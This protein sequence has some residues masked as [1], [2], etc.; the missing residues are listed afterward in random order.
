M[1]LN[2]RTESERALKS[3]PSRNLEQLLEDLAA[4]GVRWK[5][6]EPV[7]LP[8]VVFHL[9]SGRD[10]PGW[11]LDLHAD[12]HGGR[13]VLVRSTG[14]HHAAQLDIAHVP[15]GNVEALTVQDIVSLDKPPGD[16]IEA[17]TRVELQRRL[18][19]AYEIVAQKV[20]TPI[21]L[22]IEDGEDSARN[23][24]LD[25]LLKLVQ[26]AIVELTTEQPRAADALRGKVKKIRLSVGLHH[27]LVFAD[28][29]LHVTTPSAW[30]SRSPYESVK[31]E[32]AA[33][34]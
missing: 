7:R 1:G 2:E 14:D 3:W 10:L 26:R 32:L 11:V 18:V 23:E 24:P 9:R 15:L 20:G 28:G 22:E 12:R 16:V 29:T 17:P 4:L 27:H 31:R 33:L 5:A 25:W 13:T 8:Q 30:N 34:L 6:G 21:E 19:E